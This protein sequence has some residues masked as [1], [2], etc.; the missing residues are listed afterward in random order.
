M[1]PLS[2]GTSHALICSSAEQGTAA[3]LTKGLGK[4]MGRATENSDPDVS[5][6]VNLRNLPHASLGGG[7]AV[8]NSWRLL[9]EAILPS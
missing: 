4:Y 3:M 9:T 5:V 7:S 6:T 1:M 8:K 2:T